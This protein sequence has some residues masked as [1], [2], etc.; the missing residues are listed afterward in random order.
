MAIRIKNIIYLQYV[1]KKVVNGCGKTHIEFLDD[2][3]DLTDGGVAIGI[4]VTLNEDLF[5]RA[6]VPV[7]NLEGPNAFHDLLLPLQPKLI[8]SH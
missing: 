5:D 1:H 7:V 6:H 8:R 3:S 4:E 2:L